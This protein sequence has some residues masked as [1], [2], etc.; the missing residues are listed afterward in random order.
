MSATKTRTDRTP[1]SVDQVDGVLAESGRR[2]DALRADGFAGLLPVQRAKLIGLRRERARIAE[3]HGEDGPAVAAIDRKLATSHR[4][5]VAGRAEHDRIA[6][7]APER[8]AQ[9]WL[10]HGYVRNP[11]GFPRAGYLVALY[12]DD[13]GREAP[14]Q[15]TTTNSKGYFRLR[16]GRGEEVGDTVFDEPERELG[17]G[18]DTD[19]AKT[20]EPQATG[21]DEVRAKQRAGALRRLAAALRKPLYLG[22]RGSGQSAPYIDR[23]VL[24]PSAGAVVYRDLVV[25]DEGDSGS[26]CQ[27]AT[28]LLGNSGTRELH[29][30][31]N[32]QPGCRIAAIRPDHRFYFQ[33]EAQAQRLGYDH[34]AYCYGRERSER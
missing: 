7:P 21:T 34:C 18:L 28:R 1:L 30:L 4:L 15:S 26:D 32:E 6:T 12:P 9:A 33:S 27:L 8:E 10:V 14:V 22:A 17:D 2:A 25:V 11:D 16:L 19:T 20:G 13:E 5:L 29:D 24:H 31:D 3:R 23:R